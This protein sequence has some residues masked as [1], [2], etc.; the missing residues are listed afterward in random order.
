MKQHALIISQRE[1]KKDYRSTGETFHKRIYFYGFYFLLYPERHGLL[2]TR[3]CSHVLY[4]KGSED[5][6]KKR[7]KQETETDQAH[8]KWRTDGSAHCLR[9]SRKPKTIAFGHKLDAKQDAPVPLC[10]SRAEFTT[11]MYS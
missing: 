1:M 8:I 2:E 7:R 3:T 9:G 11:A 4:Q 5:I 6:H 10:I